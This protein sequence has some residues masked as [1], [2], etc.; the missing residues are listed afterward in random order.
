[1]KKCINNKRKRSNEE[2]EKWENF[3]FD[4]I[5]KKKKSFVPIE[6]KYEQSLNDLFNKKK[7][8]DIII[9]N[10]I[11]PEIVYNFLIKNLNKSNQYQY[12]KE[13]LTTNYFKL[14]FYNEKQI[15]P[16]KKI[17]T[18]FKEIINKNETNV[19]EILNNIDFI[20]YN[21]PLIYG[22]ERVRFNYYLYLIKNKIIYDNDFAEQLSKFSYY[23]NYLNGLN[24]D[25]K[26]DQKEIDM[27]FY[28]FI[29]EITEVVYQGAMNLDNIPTIYNKINPD[30]I[31]LKNK[32]INTLIGCVTDEKN[33]H[34]VKKLNDEEY[35]ITNE[36]ENAIITEKNYNIGKLANDINNYPYYPLNLLLYRNESINYYYSKN[37]TFIERE[38]KELYDSFKNYFFEFINSEN[39]KSVFLNSEYKYAREFL[40]N[41]NYKK[42]LLNDKYFKFIPFYSDIFSGFTNKDLLLTTISAYPNIVKIIPKKLAKN[43]YKD[44]KNFCLLMA[45][46]EKFLNLLHEIPIHFIY[47][48]LHHLTDIDN[49]KHSPKR[50]NLQ[51]KK[52]NE[53]NEDGIIL[54]D[55][56]HFFEKQLFG[57][58]IRELTITNVIALLDGQSTMK[59]NEEFRKI[60]NA[61]LNINELSKMIKQS[62]GFLKVFLTYFN[63]NFENIFNA[64]KDLNKSFIS[65]KG[66]R[67]PYIEIAFN[68]TYDYINYIKSNK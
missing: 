67:E 45:I 49:I 33:N 6:A 27:I 37:K 46:G 18:V 21:L 14:L 40:N 12:L 50:T 5:G 20:G 7:I 30:F 16:F 54:K 55:G 2:E 51:E 56:G 23:L 62:S 17:L 63:I 57:N 1:M 15:N 28:Q 68:N 32:N 26:N 48:Y 29:L 58:I 31:E 3:Q 4:F 53:K 61:D 11:E 35:Y 64:I 65:T 22:I 13:A 8:D 19:N 24:Y 42:I 10:N 52:E 60:F 36:I 25:R 34:F 43:H 44:V 41:N 39:F 47:G 66:K 59:T 9:K 38:K